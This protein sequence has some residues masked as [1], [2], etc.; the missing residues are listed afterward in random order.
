[1]GGGEEFRVVKEGLVVEIV[2]G[3]GC[4]K[5]SARESSVRDKPAIGEV[6]N[7]PTLTARLTLP[8]VQM[9]ILTRWN[10]SKQL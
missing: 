6:R 1:M 9:S 10:N 7:C 3:K 2:F 4:Q 5:A 8:E